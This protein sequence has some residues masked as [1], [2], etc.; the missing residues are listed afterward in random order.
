MMEVGFLLLWAFLLVLLLL[1][2]VTL[3]WRNGQRLT[4]LERQLATLQQQLTATIVRESGQLYTQFECDRTLR[5]RLG[6]DAGLNVSHHWS[7]APDFLLLVAQYVLEHKPQQI[8]ECSSGLSTVILARCCA[9]NGCGRVV[10]LEHDAQFADKTRAELQRYHLMDWA[11]VIDG[12]TDLIFF[13]HETHE[14]DEKIQKKSHKY[15]G[16]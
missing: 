16:F 6:L 13:I 11:E 1:L 8:V 2:M 4:A 7:A 5:D 9:I 12:T 10:S 14:I 15:E 3:I